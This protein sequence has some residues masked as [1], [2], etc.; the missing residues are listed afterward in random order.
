MMLSFTLTLL[1]H[2]SPDAGARRPFVDQLLAKVKDGTV[3]TESERDRVKPED[4][5]HLARAYAETTRWREKTRLIEV[6]QDSK[7]PVLTEVWWDAL[8]VPDCNDDV[9]WEVRAIALAHLDQDLTR[10]STY[11]DDRKACR[12]AVQKRLAERKRRTKK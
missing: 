7:D 1:L 11:Y 4:M 6:I 12:A 8:D 2:A 5:V 10:F 3:D 9:C